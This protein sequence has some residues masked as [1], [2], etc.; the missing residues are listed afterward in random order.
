MSLYVFLKLKG[1]RLGGSLAAMFTIRKTNSRRK[2]LMRKHNWINCTKLQVFSM[3]QNNFS[4][5]ELHYCTEL[6]LRY[7][8]YSYLWYY[9][10]R[11]NTKG[12][13]GKTH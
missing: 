11:S 4:S 1:K 6:A 9:S 8:I 12:Y 2:C 3:P 7:E 10:L 13:G 5:R